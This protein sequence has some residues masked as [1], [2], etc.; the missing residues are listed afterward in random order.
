MDLNY[1]NIY[2]KEACREG[3]HM[4]LLDGFT[5]YDDSDIRFYITLRDKSITFSKTIIDVL[6]RPAFVHMYIDKDGKRLAFQH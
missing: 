1:E 6:R 2:T 3:L 5:L 4:G